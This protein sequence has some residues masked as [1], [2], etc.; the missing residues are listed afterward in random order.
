MRPVM[1][2]RVQRV[3]A[4]D[5]YRLQLVFTNGETRVFD[6]HPY[7]G[8]PVFRELKN[9]ALFRLVRPMLGSIAWRNGQDLCPDTLYEES[10]PVAIRK[11]VRYT[12][13]RMLPRRVAEK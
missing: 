1:N 6:M 13:R 2:P 8:Y 5:D 7:L 11:R 4:L 12:I 9:P 10:Q 3:K